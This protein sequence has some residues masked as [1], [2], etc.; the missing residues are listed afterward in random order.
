[1]FGAE[2]FSAELFSAELF[3]AE[4]FS[5]E[6]F[7][8]ETAA[9]NRRCRIVGA[10]TYP[11]PFFYLNYSF[12]KRIKNITYKIFLFLKISMPF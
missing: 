12:S 7:S 11:T 5:A 10:E 8:A 1:M 9:P 2:L 4:L 3:S 6:L